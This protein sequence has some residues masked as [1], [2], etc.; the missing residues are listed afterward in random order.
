MPTLGEILN[1]N[2]PQKLI[3]VPKGFKLKRISECS[4]KLSPNGLL[5]L[6]IFHLNSNGDL[7]YCCYSDICLHWD[8]VIKEIKRCVNTTRPISFDMRLS[9]KNTESCCDEEMYHGI[10][11]QAVLDELKE[12]SEKYYER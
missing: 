8:E 7:G 2:V 12:I 3:H 11:S 1:L 10:V 4:T 5:T 6:S 9:F